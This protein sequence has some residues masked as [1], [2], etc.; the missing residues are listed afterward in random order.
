[1]IY[2]NYR[3]YAGINEILDDVKYSLFMIGYNLLYP[4]NYINQL[5]IILFNIYK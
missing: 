2:I 4:N 3:L 5:F 1:M